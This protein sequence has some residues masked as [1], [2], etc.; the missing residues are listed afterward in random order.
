MLF[1]L[2]YLG[3]ENFMQN[4]QNNAENSQ[5][6]NVRFPLIGVISYRIADI[7]IFFVANLVAVFCV[8][9]ISGWAGIIVGAT[10]AVIMVVKTDSFLD[11][12][13]FEESNRPIIRHQPVKNDKDYIEAFKILGPRASLAILS[14]RLE[15]DFLLMY[16]KH[17][18]S[19]GVDIPLPKIP[20]AEAEITLKEG[21][22][23]WLKRELKSLEDLERT[24]TDTISL[25]MMTEPVIADDGNVYDRKLL[26]DH[27]DS[28]R[29][30]RKI[31]RCPK[32]RGQRL[33]NPQ[34]FGESRRV[35][36]MVTHV[37]KVYGS[38]EKLQENI[39]ILKKKI[40]SFDSSQVVASPS[41]EGY[42]K[43]PNKPVAV[44]SNTSTLTYAINN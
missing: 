4:R 18:R 8:L 19:E 29:R 17:L 12:Y 21:S 33:R 14:D 25:E 13:K 35:K 22:K 5:R 38:L 26:Q 16:C 42:F 41:S 10:L 15:G 40:A 43:S 2:P 37:K 28:R 27:Y 44:V 30:D 31:P 11:K 1:H 32:D 20:E 23:E 36:A 3:I 34:Y 6:D 9:A 24:V 7:G 39:T